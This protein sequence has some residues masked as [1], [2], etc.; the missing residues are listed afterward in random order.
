MEDL[1]R[2]ASAL[3]DVDID[4]SALR[5][6]ELD[7]VVHVLAALHATV[8]ARWLAAVGEAE[9]RQLHRR[10]GARDTGAWIAALT[11]D[12]AGAAR[13]DVELAS[14]LASTPI[15]ASALEDGAVSKAQAAELVRGADLPADVQRRLVAAAEA[16]SVEKVAAA[17]QRACLEHGVPSAP[18]RPALSLSRR[19]DHVAVEGVLDVV[20]GE[21]LDV[22]VHAAVDVLGLPSEPPIAE[23]RARALGAIARF[24]LDRHQQLTTT[25]AGRPH[26]LVIV[27]LDVL[28]GRSGVG[29]LG[30]GAVVTGEEARRLA[31]DANITRVVTRGRSE[32][33]D[34]GSATRSVSP[35]LAKAIIFRDRHCR[36]QHCSTPSW[37]CDVH[38][39]RPWA[40]GGSTSLDNLGLLCWFHHQHIHQQGADRLTT[41]ANG[42]WYLAAPAQAA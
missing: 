31:M 25:R 2:V 5:D 23:R 18:L 15:V 30:S 41:D 1:R 26:V 11:G 27:D 28:E 16:V 21:L 37:A 14:R 22:A 42:R 35:A 34:V 20:D 36:F 3:D 6:D 7:H 33:L 29:V 40:Q 13:R 4:V 9:R 19:H 10:H 38:R 39:R 32:P 12:R 17:V 24:F 8:Q